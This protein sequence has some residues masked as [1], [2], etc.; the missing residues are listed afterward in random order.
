MFIQARMPRST[1]PRLN[2]QRNASRLGNRLG[3]PGTFGAILL[4]QL[5]VS[6]TL[7][8]LLAELRIYWT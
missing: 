7:V 1:S 8:D 3:T 5:L 4:N 6:H 2:Q